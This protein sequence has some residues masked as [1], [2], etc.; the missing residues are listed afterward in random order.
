MKICLKC[1]KCNCLECM[2]LKKEELKGEYEKN[3]GNAVKVGF[4]VGQ[5]EN[6]LRKLSRYMSDESLDIKKIRM[7]A[8]KLTD[9]ILKFYSGKIVTDI[10]Y[11]NREL[12]RYQK[13]MQKKNKK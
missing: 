1:D 13:K 12:R 7:T 2:K 8:E 4:T 6:E 11:S 10:N 9:D 3:K 5:L